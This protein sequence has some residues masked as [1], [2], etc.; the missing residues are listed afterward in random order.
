V[1][2]AGTFADPAFHGMLVADQVR[3][4]AYSD[5]IA[6]AVQ[7]GDA[8][9]DI[10]S[11][12]GLLSLFACQ[13]GA[14]KVY[15]V[16][17]T[18]I[19]KL[20]RKLAAANGYADRIEFIE[21]DL[22]T[23]ELPE[24]VNLVVSEL[25]SQAI[26]GQHLERLTAHARQNFLVDGGKMLPGR[27]MYSAMPVDAE[28]DRRRRWPS[29]DAYQLN[30][31]P[32]VEA[33]A[34]RPMPLKLSKQLPLSSP[35]LIYTYDG[36]SCDGRARIRAQADYVIEQ[37]GSFSGVAAWFDAD[38]G[39]GIRLGNQ[40]DNISWANV[41]FPIAEAVAVKPG[42][43]VEF[44]LN[45]FEPEQGPPQFE[46]AFRLWADEHAV[47]PITTARYSTVAGAWLVS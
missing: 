47:E 31:R 29:T 27:V 14:R 34:H 37:S 4:A 33:I 35:E 3:C 32:L 30:L 13:A 1:H 15:S 36:Y 7:A 41:L 8:V 44:K 45:G 20:A 22:I 38:L 28:S 21:A 39:G 40:Q 6:A 42:A 46:W 16:E 24:R 18:P 25:M 9:L 26:F 17:R 5:A 10:G 43:R 12:S 19:I 2:L 23:V 11:G